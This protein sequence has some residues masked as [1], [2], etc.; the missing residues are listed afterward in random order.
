MEVIHAAY[1]SLAA[2]YHPDRNGGSEEAARVMRIINTSY[3]ALC[4]PIRKREHD[5][6]IDNVAPDPIPER[7]PGP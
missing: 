2:M 1:R 7:R 5:R 3:A 6:W 4:D